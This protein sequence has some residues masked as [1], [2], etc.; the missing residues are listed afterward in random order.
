MRV[1]HLNKTIELTKAEAK[2][3][4]I[5]GSEEY[6]EFLSAQRDYPKYRVEYSKSKAKSK[7][8][9]KGLTFDYMEFYIKKNGSEEQA[10]TFTDL[11]NASDVIGVGAVG[12][13]EVKKWFLEQFP[14]ILEYGKKI[15]IILKRNVA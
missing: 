8:G 1:N 9:M 14:E 6:N 12:Y 2:K 13:G 11:R 10:N 5:Y 4:S 7:D 15:D 3:A